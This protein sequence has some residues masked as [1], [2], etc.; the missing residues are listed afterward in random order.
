[1]G[2]AHADV[3]WTLQLSS[4]CTASHPFGR[5][6][7]HRYLWGGAGGRWAAPGSVWLFV[8]IYVFGIPSFFYMFGGCRQGK[9]QMQF[10]W[11][12][13][14]ALLLYLCGSC[15]ALSY[16][17]CRFRWKAR[18]ENRGRLHTVELARYCIHPNYFGDLFTY[19]GW[20]LAAGSRCAL[21]LSPATLFYFTYE[22]VFT[23]PPRRHAS[24]LRRPEPWIDWA[25][26]AFLLIPV[27]HRNR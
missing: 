11:R 23:Q 21:S 1:M 6:S 3:S 24:C 14:L 9:R 26:P 4:A 8:V 2:A 20:G 22:L 16:E 7:P 25:S 12:N 15:Y 10:A 19:T 18:P 17:V 13:V 5:L 27:G